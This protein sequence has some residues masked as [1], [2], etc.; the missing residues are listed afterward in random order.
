[1]KHGLVNKSLHAFV[2]IFLFF[3]TQL[4]GQNVGIGTTTLN[5]AKLT[6]IG[7][8]N[9]NSNTVAFI[10]RKRRHQPSAGVANHRL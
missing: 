4:C 3:A 5:R 8:A 6:V 10:W 7:T 9:N 2:V 1:M